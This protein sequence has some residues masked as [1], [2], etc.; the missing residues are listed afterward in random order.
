MQRG[1]IWQLL[2]FTLVGCE[3]DCTVC[4]RENTEEDGV[5]HGDYL[6]ICNSK[7]PEFAADTILIKYFEKGGFICK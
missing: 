3:R 1:V 5:T 6:R 7:L 2:L 4:L